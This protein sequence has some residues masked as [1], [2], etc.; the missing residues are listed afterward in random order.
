M[1][2]HAVITGG[3]RG[4]GLAL[5]KAF[6]SHGWNI[7]FSGTTPQ[8]IEHALQ[9][10][11]HSGISGDRIHGVVCNVERVSDITN[12]YTQAVK[13]F[14]SVDVWINN[15]AV[16]QPK[17]PLSVCSDRQI[18]SL[19]RI[20]ISGPVNVCRL[21]YPLMVQQGGGAIYNMEGF[22]SRGSIMAGRTLYGTSK[23][24]LRYFTRSFALETK[25]SPVTIGLIDPGLSMTDML[26]QALPEHVT[27]SKRLPLAF[28]MLIYDTETVA[29]FIVRKIISNRGHAHTLTFLTKRRR[30]HALL[31]CRK[32][33]PDILRW[34]NTL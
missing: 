5:V 25:G 18:N 16:F 34:F 13:K 23:R 31:T 21:I 30:V 10:L 33:K 9:T 17:G 19:F 29:D 22:G 7:T 12:L 11:G 2:K 4:L 32:R 3:T 15:A 24:A 27:K 26:R 20:N 6:V 8:N 14:S 28:R 1:D